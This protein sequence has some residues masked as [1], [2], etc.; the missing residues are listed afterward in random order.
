MDFQPISVVFGKVRVRVEFEGA[1]YEVEVDGVAAKVFISSESMAGTK[2]AIEWVQALRSLPESDQ[3][4]EGMTVRL[5]KPC[6]CG[7]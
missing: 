2:S 3:P 1:E 4:A 5:K 6:G 7:S